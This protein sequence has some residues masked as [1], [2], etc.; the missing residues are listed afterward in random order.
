MSGRENAKSADRPNDTNL[1]K[2]WGEKKL[3]ESENIESQRL[4]TWCLKIGA[5]VEVRKLTK[6]SFLSDCIS[7]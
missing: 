4:Y 6:W 3:S 2:Y 5:E 7:L 1:I